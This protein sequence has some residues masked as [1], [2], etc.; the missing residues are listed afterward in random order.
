ME[1][2][3]LLIYVAII[4]IIVVGTLL[5]LVLF[6]LLGILTKTDHVFGYIDHVRGLLESWEQI[7]IKL[8]Q[9]IFGK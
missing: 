5:S 4:F 2:I 3:T 8:L 1:P 6:R 7:P 9:K